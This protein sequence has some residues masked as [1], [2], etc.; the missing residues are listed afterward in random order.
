MVD[1]LQTIHRKDSFMYIVCKILLHTVCTLSVHTQC[2]HSVCTLSV[3]TQC[4]QVHNLC[5]KYLLNSLAVIYPLKEDNTN[6]MT[7]SLLCSLS[8]KLLDAFC[9]LLSSLFNGLLCILFNGSLPLFFNGNCN[10]ILNLN[11]SIALDC[12]CY[13][14]FGLSVA[15]DFPGGKRNRNKKIRAQLRILKCIAIVK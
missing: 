7:K 11:D 12:S 14:K 13:F 15:I 4:A 1:I 5:N 10:I 8:A 9:G 3:H 2:A 6:M